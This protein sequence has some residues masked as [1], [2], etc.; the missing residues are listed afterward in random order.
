[1]QNT[2][3]NSNPRESAQ[4]LLSTVEKKEPNLLLHTHQ[5]IEVD[6]ITEENGW[7]KEFTLAYFQ[8]QQELIAAH[9]IQ[10]EDAEYKMRQRI[11]N[12]AHALGCMDN[13]IEFLSDDTNTYLG[14]LGFL[15]GL[16]AVY[17]T[18]SKQ[19]A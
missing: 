10:S 11:V 16:E 19:A 8:E 1:M 3:T 14:I 12:L 18:Q 17:Y 13:A 9:N 4:Y 6:A 15:Q 5:V 7:P 2:T